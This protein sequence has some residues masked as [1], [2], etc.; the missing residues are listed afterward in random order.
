MGSPG[1]QSILQA[2]WRGLSDGSKMWSGQFFISYQLLLFGFLAPPCEKDSI[3]ENDD[4][5]TSKLLSFF[6]NNYNLMAENQEQ[7]APAQ[8][9]T[10]QGTGK[11]QGQ[12]MAPI[13]RAAEPAEDDMLS[14]ILCNAFLPLW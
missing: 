5:I 9:A 7:A 6:Y 8:E 10:P 11:A 12:E 13:F 2:R 4:S 14:R 1:Y 3:A